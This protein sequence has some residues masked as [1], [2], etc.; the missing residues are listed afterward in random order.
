[1]SGHALNARRYPATSYLLRVKPPRVAERERGAVLRV[2][3]VQ[4]RE[5][6]IVAVARLHMHRSRP[7]H[8]QTKFL[9]EYGLNANDV[10]LIV[11]HADRDGSG[12]VFSL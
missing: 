11:Y 9:S 12:D 3:S 5:S 10:P 1:M 2:E 7:F 8:M 4:P 6:L